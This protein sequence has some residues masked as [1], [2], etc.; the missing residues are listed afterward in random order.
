MREKESVYNF[1]IDNFQYRKG[2]RNYF[3]DPCAARDVVG[4]FTV[5]VR[6][7]TIA[8]SRRGITKS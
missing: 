7:N 1:N 5:E 3:V 2:S 4:I 6:E 8:E